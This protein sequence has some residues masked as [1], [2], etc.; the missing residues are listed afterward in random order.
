VDFTVRCIQ[1]TKKT[2]TIKPVINI[3]CKNKRR[4]ESNK[5]FSPLELKIEKIE[6]SCD[7]TA[8]IPTYFSF[9]VMTS[10]AQL[11]A[12]ETVGKPIVL[13]SKIIA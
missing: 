4:K 10:S 12:A 2:F 1:R 9:S 6:I 5:L 11:I 13:E 8:G 7:K 3:L